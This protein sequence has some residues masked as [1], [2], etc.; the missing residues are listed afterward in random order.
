MKKLILFVLSVFFL[1]GCVPDINPETGLIFSIKP[2]ELVN[3]S[4][5]NLLYVVTD[6]RSQLINV[7]IYSDEKL[8]AQ[9]NVVNNT[10][11]NLTIELDTAK[12]YRT[13]YL[14]ATDESGNTAKVNV[15]V[16][17]QDITAPIFQR[18]E[19]YSAE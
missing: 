4:K 7:S 13:F 19:I 8:L 1:A 15:T 12:E 11:M 16:R 5:V 17:L 3:S 6:D 2:Q 14:I 10:L 18:V 9:G